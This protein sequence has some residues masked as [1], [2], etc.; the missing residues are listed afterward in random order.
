ML[1]CRYDFADDGDETTY[2]DIPYTVDA[3]GAPALGTPRQ[4]EQ[5]WVPLK[6]LASIAPLSS[7]AAHLARHAHALVERTTDLHQRRV[8]SGRTLSAANRTLIADAVKATAAAA[9][10]LQ[11]L[12]DAA[13][14]EAAKAVTAADV[15]RM[16]VDQLALWSATL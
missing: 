2:Y 3:G 8:K 10:G 4:V 16:Q 9:E 5:V 15:Y 12:L 6:A 14:P 1:A 11:A 7:D 13:D